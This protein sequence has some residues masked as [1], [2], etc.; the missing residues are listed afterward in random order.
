MSLRPRPVTEASAQR[1]ADAEDVSACALVFAELLLVQ[2]PPMDEA[3]PWVRMGTR[4][5]N[6]R[7]ADASC[8]LDNIRA[9]RLSSLV[10]APT[11]RARRRPGL[12]G[13]SRR[14]T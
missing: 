6:A 5:D 10:R 13:L 11:R 4:V 2:R 7:S 1:A 3:G 14:V 12:Y 9:Q 8:T